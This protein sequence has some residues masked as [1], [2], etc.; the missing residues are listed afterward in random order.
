MTPLISCILRK[1]KRLFQGLH[2]TL[3]RP[4]GRF[5]H[6]AL[7]AAKIFCPFFRLIGVV[8]HVCNPADC[9]SAERCI[10]AYLYDVY[11]S[12]CYLKV[13][14]FSLFFG[15]SFIENCQTHPIKRKKGKCIREHQRYTNVYIPYCIYFKTSLSSVSL[16][17][18]GS[19]VSSVGRVL[20]S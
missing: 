8:K 18:K 12:C 13:L 5:S 4:K 6:N 7:N 20:D 2:N 14:Q 1:F 11:T 16:C 19:T 17:Y 3:Q 10:L 15:L 9:S